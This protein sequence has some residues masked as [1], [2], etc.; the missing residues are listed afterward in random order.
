M[1]AQARIVFFVFV[2]ILAL[3]EARAIAEDEGPFRL[4]SDAFAEGALIPTDHTCD[5][6]DRSPTLQWSGAPA[7]TQAFTLIVDDPDAPGGSFTHWIL[8]NV[9]GAA[10][11]LAEGMP[12]GKTTL[13]D[14]SLQGKS[15][16]KRPGW[17]GPCPPKGS[18]HRYEFELYALSAPLELEPGVT[19]DEVEK[20]MK[21]TTLAKTKLTGQY[22]RPTAAKP[23]P[24]PPKP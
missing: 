17:G 9:P 10:K 12:P 15:D 7:G 24:T 16:F 5:G 2:S 8:Y 22:A 19:R 1:R 13:G 21:D 11:G 3:G 18:K 6:A 14:G 23:T 4:T 20:A